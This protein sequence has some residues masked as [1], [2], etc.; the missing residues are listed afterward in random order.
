MGGV[1]DLQ[2]KTKTILVTHDC[3]CAVYIMRTIPE[4]DCYRLR[5]W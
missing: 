4:A 1:E 3:S 5:L 2:S